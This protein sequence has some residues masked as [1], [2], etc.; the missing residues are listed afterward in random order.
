[1]YGPVEVK[2]SKERPDRAV[3]EVTVKAATG[4]SG[5]RT[6][7][8]RPTASVVCTELLPPQTGVKERAL[9]DVLRNTCEQAVLTRLH[10]HAS[11]N[12]TLQVERDDGAVSA[13]SQCGRT[14]ALATG[15]I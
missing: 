11:I 14:A 5:R 9:E 6:R 2:Q 4:I 12:V 15:V 13:A 7:V 8:A 1:M 3:V 10:P